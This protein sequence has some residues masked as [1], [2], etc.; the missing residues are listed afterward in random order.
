MKKF[1]I[2]ELDEL[3]AESIRTTALQE[4][5]IKYCIQDLNSAIS[6]LHGRAENIYYVD[7]SSKKHFFKKI[8]GLYFQKQDVVWVH[9]PALNKL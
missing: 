8:R 4:Q 9:I 2:T 1:T 7:K 5:Y 3:N 6:I